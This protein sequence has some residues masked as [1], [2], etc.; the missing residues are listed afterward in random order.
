MHNLLGQTIRQ[1][2]LNEITNISVSDLEAGVYLLNVVNSE[3]KVIASQKIII[4][5]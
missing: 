1:G 2:K 3:N 5:H 4:V